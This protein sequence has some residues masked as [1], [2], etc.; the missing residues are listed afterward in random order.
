MEEGGADQPREIGGEGRAGV[1]IAPAEIR[2]HRTRGLAE[3]RKSPTDR[4]VQALF[5]TTLG[6]R[7]AVDMREAW[8]GYEDRLIARLGG[9]EQRDQLLA[10]LARIT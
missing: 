7:F 1:A 9:A 2:G 10:L 3:R 5:L 8:Q 4:R 6:E